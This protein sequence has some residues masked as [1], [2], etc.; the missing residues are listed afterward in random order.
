MR[1]GSGLLVV[2][3]LAL[4]A[5]TA[6]A[7]WNEPGGA[8]PL[9]RDAARYADN[10]SL[11][12][13]GSVPYVSWRESD[14]TNFEVRVARL[15]ASGNGWEPVGETLNPASPINRSSTMGSFETAITSIGGVPYVAFNEQDGTNAELRVSRLN[16]Q[17]TGWEPVGEATSPASPINN[18]PTIAANRVA[19]AAIGGVPYVAWREMDDAVPPNITKI[20]VSRLAADGLSWTQVVGGANPINHSATQSGDYPSIASIGGVPYVSWVECDAGNCSGNNETRVA[21]YDSGSN[22][23]VEPVG[24]PSPINQSV[25]GYSDF[26]SLTSVGGV[27]YVAWSETDGTNSEVR[28]ARLNGTGTAWDKV[29]QATDP[30][31]PIN[32]S[33]TNNAVYPNIASFDG[34]P[35]VAW[36]ECDDNACA[37]T[38]QVRVARLNDAGSGWDELVGGASPVNHDPAER[39]LRPSLASIGGVPYLAWSE[40]C[41]GCNDDNRVRAGRLEPDFLGQSETV[42]DT[43]ATLATSVRTY[44]VPYPIASQYGQ[45]SGLG[46]QTGPVTVR[47]GNGDSAALNLAIGPLVPFTTYSWRAIGTDGARATAASSTRSFKTT[48]HGAPSLAASMTNR[49]FRTTS[50]ITPVTAKR[51]RA[52]RGTAFNYTL[53]EA[54]TLTIAIERSAKGRRVKGKCRRR[55]KGNKGKRRCT[56]YISAGK[57]TRTGKAGVN[58]A[59]FSGRIGKR[60]LK[61]GR[62]RAKLQATDAAGNASKTRTLSFTIV[63]R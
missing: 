32:R 59:P 26:T 9:N 28:V 21:R 50:K 34:V 27:P 33:G 44:G 12:V 3:S 19:I 63:K 20:R 24:G 1:F 54:A 58:K 36:S 14:G 2:L 8:P 18:D 55:T 25:D 52:P 37:G 40:E 11:T 29:G 61:S 15:N 46:T 51:K 45:G 30:A 56:L 41:S 13:I 4:S 62:Y 22:T 5:S 48:D 17:G 23:W 43:G 60:A 16:A 31:S 49:R 6:S 53:S 35:Y 10:A 7:A 39:A 57:L 42:A 47:S 38:Y